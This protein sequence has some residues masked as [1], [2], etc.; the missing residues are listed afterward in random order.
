[1][2]HKIHKNVNA[3]QKAYRDREKAKKQADR[4]MEFHKLG[5]HVLGMHG[6]SVKGCPLCFPITVTQ[7]QLPVTEEV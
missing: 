6:N 5:A 3:K 7:S 2:S 4:L 1:M